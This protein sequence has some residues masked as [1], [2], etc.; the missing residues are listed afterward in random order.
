[1][2]ERERERE[3]EKER[4]RERERERSVESCEFLKNIKSSNNTKS[5]VKVNERLKAKF[6]LLKTVIVDLFFFI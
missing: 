1:M 3:R 4:E 5:S 6:Q 2:R